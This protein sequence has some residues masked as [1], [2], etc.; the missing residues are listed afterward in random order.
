MTFCSL[1]RQF[2]PIPN[3]SPLALRFFPCVSTLHDPSSTPGRVIFTPYPCPSFVPPPVLNI[4][5]G[6]RC[7]LTFGVF[8]LSRVF[9]VPL[10]L[11][12]PPYFFRFC[13][14]CN[15]FLSP[16]PTFSVYVRLF[17][18][19]F[20]HM[21]GRILFLE[22]G[23]YPCLFYRAGSNL[24]PVLFLLRSGCFLFCDSCS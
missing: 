9:Q 18:L 17:L 19:H 2:S 24:P 23:H 14:D 3:P 21:L 15:L 5:P 7:R 12:G 20:F 13:V 8:R 4:P 11:F 22:V 16:T 10:L 1:A 6:F